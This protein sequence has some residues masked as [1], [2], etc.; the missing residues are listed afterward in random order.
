MSGG[1]IGRADGARRKQN[2]TKC[3]IDLKT[4]ERLRKLVPKEC[5]FVSESGILTD[6]DVLFLKNCQVDGF[7]IGRALMEAEHPKEVAA[8][9]KAL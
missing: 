6:E 7:L 9:W 1:R 3:P 8:H 5:C 4:T 2:G